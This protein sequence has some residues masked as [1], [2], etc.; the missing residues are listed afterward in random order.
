MTDTYDTQ[1]TELI[2]ATHALI[3]TA[4][5]AKWTAETTPA[6]DRAQKALLALTPTPTAKP[7]PVTRVIVRSRY[8]DLNSKGRG[9]ECYR[10]Y[11]DP[12]TDQGGWLN[13]HP[14]SIVV[15]RGWCARGIR[16]SE[17]KCCD[18]VEVPVGTLILDIDKGIGEG[19]TT[20]YQ[21]GYITLKEGTENEGAII[22]E[23]GGEYPIVR[24]CGT[25]GI[26]I[27]IVEINGVRHTFH[28]HN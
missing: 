27:H 8:R 28:T 25:K 14:D 24:H 11:L 5:A 1:V 19:G 21:V 4:L 20:S 23:G 26:G 6:L 2:N 10:M 12:S 18:K 15:Q 3:L 22:W 17:R 16:A 7:T 13:R 9:N